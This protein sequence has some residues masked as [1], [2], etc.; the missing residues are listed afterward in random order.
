M[1]SYVEDLFIVTFTS[2]KAPPFFSSLIYMDIKSYQDPHCPPHPTQLDSQEAVNSE[3][4]PGA[5]VV[6]SL[7]PSPILEA[8]LSHPLADFFSV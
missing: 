7:T 3:Q 1:V 4:L 5:L 6:S 8:L 2:S